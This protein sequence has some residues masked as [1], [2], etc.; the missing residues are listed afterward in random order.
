MICLLFA[1]CKKQAE[2]NIDIYTIDFEQCFETERQMAVSEI[3]DNVEYIELKT[4]E[5]VIVT[6][7]WDVKQIDD[8]LLIDSSHFMTGRI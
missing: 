6:R 7:V 1:G 4:P 2:R 3:A 8:Y 5:D